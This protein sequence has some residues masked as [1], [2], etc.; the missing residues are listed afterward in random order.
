VS[1]YY[2]GVRMTLDEIDE[3]TTVSE[4][5]AIRELEKHFKIVQVLS[6]G[7]LWCVEEDAIICERD[8][9]GE[10]SAQAILTWLGY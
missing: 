4:D 8:L 5:E 9:N 1:L 7:R 2:W 10:F 3:T 6:D